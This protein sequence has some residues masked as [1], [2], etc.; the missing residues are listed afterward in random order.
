MVDKITHR[1]EPS[2]G[3]TVPEL[4]VT[5]MVFA[6]VSTSAYMLLMAHIS[7]MSTVQL[8]S[9]ALSLA[10]EQIEYLRSLPYDGLA[11]QGG[12]IITSGTPIPG[13][14]DKM[15][16]ARSFTVKTD[17]SYADDA[18]DGCFNYAPAQAYL[19]R[20]GPVQ[21][22]KP[23]DTNPRDYKIADVT[24][25][26][27]SS[28]KTYAALSSQF[29]SRVA[30]T[31]GNSSA[32]SVTVVDSAGNPVA[33]AA[34]R[35]TNTT[36]SPAI[37]QTA[38]TD[39]NGTALFLDI[40]PDSSSDYVISASKT[41]YSSL[42][43]LPINGTL[44][45]TYPNINAIAQQVSNA[46]LKINP[47]ANDSLTVKV[48]DIINQPLAGVSFG[49]RGG[50]K[51]YTDPQDTTY[52]F[53]QVVTSD[54]SGI[55][56]LGSLVPGE[57]RICYNAD[58]NPCASG[59]AYKL[60]VL[61]AAYGSSSHQPFIIPAGTSNIADGGS[62]Q[63]VTLVVST[64]S[65]APRIT[66]ITPSSVVSSAGDASTTEITITGQNLSGANVKLR[67]GSVEITGTVSGTD[68]STSIKRIVNLSGVSQGAYEVEV[69]TAA[70][71]IVQTGTT[72]S[73]LGG[74][75]VIP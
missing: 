31:T 39:I 55:V 29:T 60:L 47:I 18:F 8:R 59:S 53:Q 28:G 61:R 15:R 5:I 65:S 72:P 17:I 45:P 40:V 56:N 36:T 68:S 38:L 70:G 73:Q 10:T 27:K 34:V 71:T 44:T 14:M 13:T 41:G 49:I 9:A 63:R 46:T 6:I 48:V 74:V 3:F 7:S 30:E 33:G 25:I 62:M 35:A 67:Q 26:D 1:T 50:I 11:V 20:N 57:Y 52:S 51:L 32:L 23:V 58:P 54:A 16:S 4:I 42:S 64:S 12:T 24:I 22:S 69:A 66:T 21:G 37:D 2:Q 43:T 75:N 19:C